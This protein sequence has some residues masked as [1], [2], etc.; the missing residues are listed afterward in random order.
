MA[1]NASAV[2]W[3]SILV[4]RLDSVAAVT[5][6]VLLSSLAAE[7]NLS[8]VGWVVGG[9]ALLVSIVSRWPYGAL[10]VLIATSA[11]P[12]FFVEVFGWKARP[13]HFSSVILFLALGVRLLFYKRNVRLEKLD[14]WVLAYVVV[15]YISSA[16]GSSAPS[17]TLRW[18]LQNNLAVLPYFLIRMLVPDLEVLKSAFKIL[19]SIGVVESIYGIVCY[20]SHHVFGTTFGMDFAYLVDVA[21]PYGSIFEPNLF[22]AYTGCCALLGLAVYLIGSRRLRYLVCFLIASLASVLSLSRAALIALVIASAW[23]L[24]Q[25]RHA[26]NKN[27][28]RPATLALALAVILVIAVTAVGG[29][30]KERFSDLFNQG[31]A[32][33]TAVTRLI[34]IVEALQ[35]VPQ[36]PLLGSGTASFQLSFD[37]GKY[38]PEWANN[39]A[40]VGNVIVRILHDTGFV[41]LATVVGLL[42]SVWWKIRGELQGRSYEISMLLGLS[43]GA[44]LY[45]I[46]F[47]ATDGTILAFSWVH[48]GFLASA[49]ILI[50]GPKHNINGGR[51]PQASASGPSQVV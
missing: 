1:E 8:W 40:W 5:A 27:R 35:E 22:G 34:V 48:L 32:E 38:V 7:E 42:G 46:S 12:R 45:S 6:I 51:I 49:A 47:Q 39:P 21:A 18:A 9:A 37:F 44:L 33:E 2:F 43:A 13:E 26:T 36:H 24:W 17:A 19:L 28:T 4:R 50:N 41:G 10:L 14:Y 16:F 20:L 25:A 3:Q 29:V 30:L 23:V 31:F 15:N 11:M